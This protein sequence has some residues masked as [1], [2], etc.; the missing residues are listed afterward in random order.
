M[1]AYN[2]WNVSATLLHT[3]IPYTSTDGWLDMFI[4]EAFHH[5]QYWAPDADWIALPNT[6]MEAGDRSI[7]T[8]F[9]HAAMMSAPRS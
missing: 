5:Y 2:A 1:Q 7:L 9:G 4:H 3:F 6:A 8:F